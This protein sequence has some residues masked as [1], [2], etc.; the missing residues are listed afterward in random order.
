MGYVTPEQ[1]QRAKQM[2]LLTYLQNYDPQALVHVAGSTYCTREHDSL[3][4]SNGKWHWFSRGIGGRSALDYLIKVQGYPF[5]RAVETILGQTA[6]MPSFSFVQEERQ[7]RTLLMPELTNSPNAVVKYL[8]GR[9]IHPEIIRH[10]LEHKLLFE[11]KRYHNAVFVGYDPEGKARYAAL[12]GTVGN[13]KGEVSGSDKRYSFSVEENKNAKHLHIFESAIDLMSYA[14]LEILDGRS[15]KG[16]ALLSLAGVFKTKRENVVPLALSQ[17]LKAHPEVKTLHLH[18]DNDD[19]GR[20]AAFCI[21]E[22]LRGRYE[23][24]N[25]PPSAGKDVNEQ[26]QIKL[27]ICQRKVEYER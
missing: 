24:S 8:I 13:F 21:S 22:G 27:E 9:G 3:K 26:L 23:I 1:I 2:D 4:I 7:P 6:R 17:Y 25:E 15:W 5:T 14:T 20:G 18:L 16:D 10:C 12:R 11:T 19:I